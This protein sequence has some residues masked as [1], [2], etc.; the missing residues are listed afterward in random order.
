VGAGALFEN[1]LEGDA[2]PCSRPARYAL[3]AIYDVLPQYRPVFRLSALAFA[4]E[5]ALFSSGLIRLG[6]FF[7]V[8]DILSFLRMLE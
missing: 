5:S 4:A 8:F 2:L 6:R 3:W 7:V 1:L